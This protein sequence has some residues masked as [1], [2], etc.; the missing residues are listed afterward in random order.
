M[1]RRAF[2]AAMG[3][4]GMIGSVAGC[5]APAGDASRQATVA[6]RGAEVMPFDL[7]ATTHTFTKTEAG[8]RQ[9]VT[10]HDPNDRTQIDLIRQH[11]QAERANFANGNF[12]DPARIHGMDMPG[13]S[14][15]SAGY[16]RITVTYAERPDGAELTY[17]TEDAALVAAIHAWFDR[18]LMDHG[19]HA[20]AG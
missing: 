15:L 17:T 19:T 20:T 12:S 2:A 5:A 9:V 10:A 1:S 13:V 14:E 6:S 3:L 7:N 16:A 11:L 4:I 8:G 18:Q